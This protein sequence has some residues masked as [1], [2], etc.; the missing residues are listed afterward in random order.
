MLN[1]LAEMAV[2]NLDVQKLIQILEV[3]VIYN[4]KFGDNYIPIMQKEIN[5][6]QVHIRIWK[7]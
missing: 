5:R 1:S 3:L 6:V 7:N 4:V 2:I